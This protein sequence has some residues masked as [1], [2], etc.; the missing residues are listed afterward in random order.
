VL[1]FG[2]NLVQLPV[3]ARSGW[4]SCWLLT[5]SRGHFCWGRPYVVPWAHDE[6]L[7]WVDGDPY[8][9][10]WVNPEAR[11]YY[12]PGAQ[13]YGNTVPGFYVSQAE[14]REAGHQSTSRWND[15]LTP[16]SGVNVGLGVSP[17]P[18]QR[19]SDLGRFREST[20]AWM[21]G[22]RAIDTPVTIGPD[23]RPVVGD[24]QSADGLLTLT[25]HNGSDWE[26]HEAT[27]WIAVPG[28][29]RRS[30]RLRGQAMPNTEAT[31]TRIV[32]EPPPPVPTQMTRDA[33][34]NWDLANG[35]TWELVRVR[36]IPP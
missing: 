2:R 23:G 10:V 11:V 32:S 27:I 14:A 17:Q 15:L 4:R 8:L 28:Q 29:P 1:R 22:P 35:F 26:V 25:L 16:L 5:C 33:N 12:G 7:N 3:V 13:A 21:T 31:F 6:Y 19:H 34:G 36:G 20:L 18:F 30:H 24:G 9:K